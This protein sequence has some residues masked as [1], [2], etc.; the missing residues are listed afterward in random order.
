MTAA[1]IAA[2]TAAVEPPETVTATGSAVDVVTI[3]AIAVV[4]AAASKPYELLRV[5]SAPCTFAVMPAD[6][7]VAVAEVTVY[8]TSLVYA[9]LAWSTGVMVGIAGTELSVVLSAVTCAWM[10]LLR[11]AVNV[12]PVATVLEMSSVVSVA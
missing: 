6:V 4:T 11:A 1:T 2:E 3:V 10:P 7:T 5:V 8:V 12:V 9:T